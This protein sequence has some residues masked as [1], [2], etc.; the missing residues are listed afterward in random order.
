MNENICIPPPVSVCR[1]SAGGAFY[2]IGFP[3]D[4]ST[5]AC[6]QQCTRASATTSTAFNSEHG[7]SWRVSRT[8]RSPAVRVSRTRARGQQLNQ[9][10]IQAC[11]C[12]RVAHTDH[13][14][15]QQQCESDVYS[16]NRVSAIEW[17]GVIARAEETHEIDCASR[18]IH[19]PTNER[20]LCT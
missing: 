5:T 8:N 15:A 6:V 10:C 12:E 4:A 9:Q 2:L 7:S 3:L 16:S 20:T 17:C 18:I 13:S 19:T 1:I 14:F 11:R